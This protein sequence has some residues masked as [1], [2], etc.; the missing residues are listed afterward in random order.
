MATAITKLRN[1]TM[2]AS[3][4]DAGK[5]DSSDEQ[6]K[7]RHELDRRRGALVAFGGIYQGLTGHGASWVNGHQV[8]RNSRESLFLA[9][10]GEIE[11]AFT[12]RLGVV[13]SRR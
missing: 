1:S 11:G 13:D 5:D 7:A 8:E 12:C 2:A 6:R 10:P 3:E 4:N 9:P